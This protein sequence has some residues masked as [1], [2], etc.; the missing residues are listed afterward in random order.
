M[1]FDMKGEETTHKAIN[2]CL[3]QDYLVYVRAKDNTL[4]Y[5]PSKNTLKYADVDIQISYSLLKS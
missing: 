3:N 4:K 1:I 2:I 5:V